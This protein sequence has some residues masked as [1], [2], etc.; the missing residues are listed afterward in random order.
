MKTAVSLYD[1]TLRD[2][3]QA[4]G[5]NFSLQDKLRIAEKL[6]TFGMD[7]IEGGWPGSNEKDIAFF[8][9]ARKLKFKHAKLAAF[10]STRRAHTSA[11]K[12]PQVRLLVDAHTPVVTIYGKSWLFHV[13]EVLRTTPDENL[14]MIAD[15]VRFLKKHGREVIYDAEH[16]FD[17]YKDNSEYALK[18]L[19]A[20]AEAG[21]DRLVLCDTNGGSLASEVAEIT[22]AV[23]TVFRTPIGIHTHDDCGLGVANALA[24]VENGATQVQ[25]TVNGYGERAGN[26]NLTSVIPNLQLKMGMKVVTDSSLRHLQQLSAFVDDLANLRPDPRAPF[27]GE[28]AFAHKGGT[29]VN[30][31]SKSLRS[32]EHIEPELVGNRRRVLVGELSGR[33]NVLLKAR[34]LGIE[35]NTDSPEV[36]DNLGQINTMEH[37]GFEFEYADA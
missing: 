34:E 36:R 26:C 22:E 29:H 4:E 14:A 30:A 35:L 21:A 3:T 2:G 8:K 24:A 19:A 28:S 7:Y 9:A 1:T 11:A 12:D 15:T 6:D 13:K 33:S 18:S 10:G 16:F 5:V 20:A 17:A 23:C 27:V 25:G 31:V 37:A 32:Y